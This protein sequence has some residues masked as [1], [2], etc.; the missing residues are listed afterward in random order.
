MQNK[1]FGSVG[2]YD[3]KSI[4]DQG[5]L[6]HFG[7]ISITANTPVVEYE[8]KYFKALEY[9]FPAIPADKTSWTEKWHFTPLCNGWTNG[10]KDGRTD[11]RRDEA[12]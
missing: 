2:K 9:V 3:I 12:Q 1:H 7:F 5:L 8:I 6:D 10:C 4:L 11:R